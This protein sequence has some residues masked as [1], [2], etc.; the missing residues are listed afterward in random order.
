MGKPGNPRY[1]CFLVEAKAVNFLKATIEL[2]NY[3]GILV[4]RSPKAVFRAV[5][6]NIY[7]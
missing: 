7:K 2:K 5:V 4:Y 3:A 1:L 6:A